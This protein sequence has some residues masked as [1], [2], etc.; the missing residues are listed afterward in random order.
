[1][2]K[3]AIMILS[4]LLVPAYV[5]AEKDFGVNVPEW[6]DFAPTAFINVKEPKG[7]GKLN[8]TAKYWYERKT[9]FESA[10][11]ECKALENSEERFA[12]YET[13]KTKQYKENNDYN[14]RIE[15]QMNGMTTV[16]GMESKTDTM[17][18]IGG[19]INQMTQF[20]PSE[21]R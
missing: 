7:L 2:K 9:N 1:M 21:V 20:M 10:L 6:S 15:A 16:P 3:T 8:V 4:L 18:P 11:E 19:Y 13:L 5:F 14:A 12:C 17:L